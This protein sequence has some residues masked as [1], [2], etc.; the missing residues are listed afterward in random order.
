MCGLVNSY[1]WTQRVDYE[2]LLKWLVTPLNSTKQYLLFRCCQGSCSPFLT[3]RISI[4]FPEFGLKLFL[5]FVQVSVDAER[6]SYERSIIK[7][8]VACQCCIRTQKYS[9]FEYI[10]VL[11][12]K[13]PFNSLFNFEARGN[14]NELSLRGFQHSVLP[15]KNQTWI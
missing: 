8:A 12:R 3:L 9:F 6:S 10:Y 1:L 13:P 5:A 2:G 4:N 11:K 14:L 7:I 15:S